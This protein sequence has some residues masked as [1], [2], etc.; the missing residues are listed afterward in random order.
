MASSSNPFRKSATQHAENRFSPIPSSIDAAQM[1]PPPPPTTTFRDENVPPAAAQ[2]PAVDANKAKVVKKVRVLSPPPRTPESPEWTNS[3]FGSAATAPAYA[4]EQDPF[5]N[6]DNDWDDAS[7]AATA[8]AADPLSQPAAPPAL[9]PLTAVET[10]RPVNVVANP[11]SKKKP[12]E[13][14]DLKN[15]REHAREEG[16]VLKEAQSARRSLNVDSFKR[17]LMTGAASPPSSPLPTDSFEHEP[18][19]R[20]RPVSMPPPAREASTTASTHKEKKAPPPPPSSRHGRVI[21]PVPAQSPTGTGSAVT[22]LKEKPAEPV[23]HHIESS[24]PSLSRETSASSGSS[25]SS[26][27]SASVSDEVG[28]MDTHPSALTASPDHIDTPV[29]PPASSVKKPVPVPPPRRQ[30]RSEAKTTSTDVQDNDPPPRSSM[31]SISSRSNSVRHSTNAPA[32]PPPRRT[33]SGSRQPATSHSSTHIHPP[34]VDT[35]RTSSESTSRP[36]APPPP[37]TRNPSTRRPQ[38]LYG[39]ESSH[40]RVLGEIKPRDVVAPPPPPAR[41]RGSSQS[42]AEGRSARASLDSARKPRTSADEFGDLGDAQYT[43]QT[44]DILA[45]LESLQREVDALRGKMS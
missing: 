13:T 5:N 11:F 7:A 44:V 37:P 23:G 26:S 25:T 20:P 18:A 34:D 40:R 36:M 45:D 39:L 14:A 38:S 17:L 19:D 10:Q 9:P 1:F 21:K 41:I 15:S 22:G 29:S 3:Y 4:P 2:N 42:S 6:V 31:D 27:S 43:G 33:T 8:A 24:R 12:H 35:P 28:E 16:E 32:P 30:P